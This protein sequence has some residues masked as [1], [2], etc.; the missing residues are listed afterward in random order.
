M[1]QLALSGVLAL[2]LAACASAGEPLA[3]PDSTVG[4]TGAEGST[5]ITEEPTLQT[6]PRSESDLLA[7]AEEARS[8]L[9]GRLG[10]TEDEIAVT[11]ATAVT[12]NDGSIG[13]PQPGMSYTQALVD[14]ARVTLQHDGNTYAYHRGGGDLFYCEQPAEGSFAVSEDDSGELQMTPPPG[15]ND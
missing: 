13:C 6:T 15:F 12:W 11:S 14:G 8:D 4:T 3:P 5:T 9:A 1:R 10:V 7:L 2:G